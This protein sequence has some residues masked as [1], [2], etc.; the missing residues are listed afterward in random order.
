M[1]LSCF[2]LMQFLESKFIMLFKKKFI[3]EFTLIFEIY[4]KLID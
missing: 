1:E 2:Q 4:L 3:R